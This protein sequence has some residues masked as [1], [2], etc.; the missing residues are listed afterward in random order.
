M[1]VVGFKNKIEEPKKQ[2]LKI[3]E[4]KKQFLKIE[5]QM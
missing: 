4:P 5:E 3:E 2:F 1:F